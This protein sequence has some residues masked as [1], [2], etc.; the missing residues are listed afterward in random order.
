MPY[1]TSVDIIEALTGLNFLTSLPDDT[2]EEVEGGKL[3]VKNL[4]STNLGS[5]RI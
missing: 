5:E 1:L 3:G 4:G 2:E